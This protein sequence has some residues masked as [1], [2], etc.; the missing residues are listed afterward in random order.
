MAV[1]FSRQ[2]IVVG[3]GLEGEA[4]LQVE[5]PC[6]VIMSM[7]DIGRCTDTLRP[8]KMGGYAKL[9]GVFP[10]QGNVAVLNREVAGE[11]EDKLKIKKMV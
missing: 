7:N 5:F 4:A 6:L 1:V 11:N 9:G 3:G 8:Y 2:R 10:L